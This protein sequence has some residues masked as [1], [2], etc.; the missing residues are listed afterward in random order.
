M[1]LPPR[2]ETHIRHNSLERRGRWIAFLISRP[3][4]DS[5]SDL[6]PHFLIPHPSPRVVSS[7]RPGRLCYITPSSRRPAVMGL[8]KRANVRM[9]QK[10]VP[11]A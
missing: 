2:A 4:M 9:V 11:A 6:G 5:A 10:P 8:P 1:A 3:R 7:V